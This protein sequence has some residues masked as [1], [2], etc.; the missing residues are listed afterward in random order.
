M[1]N[2][3]ILIQFKQ[4]ETMSQ[5]AGLINSITAY[6]LHINPS[7]SGMFSPCI[8]GWYTQTL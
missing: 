5:I 4:I 7:V 3:R 1:N 6:Q 8:G 2:F